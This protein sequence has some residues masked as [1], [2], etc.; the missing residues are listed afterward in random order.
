MNNIEM[1]NQIFN[2]CVIPLL[3]ILTAYLV[4]IIRT[5]M[6]EIAS[7][8]NNELAQKYI[9]MLTTTITNCVIATNQTYVEALKKKGEFNR[10]AQKEAFN[11][12]YN[13]VML[14]LSK[15]AYEFLQTI[16]NDL[17]GY[18]KT[19]IEAEVSNEKPFIS[20]A[21]TGIPVE[22]FKKE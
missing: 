2:L 9:D 4:Q 14:T 17:D 10:E 11:K 3:G 13:Q 8:T 15:E 5:K 18:I 19:M 7:K 22:E 12:T 20:T 16:Y 1:I 21:P 6:A